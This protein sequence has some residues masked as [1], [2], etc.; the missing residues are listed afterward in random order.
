MIGIRIH[1]CALVAAFLAV[2]GTGAAQIGSSDEIS[3]S[4]VGAV[5]FGMTVEQAAAAGVPLTAAA[6]ATG[7][8]CF[9]AHPAGRPG[10]SFVVRDGTI[11]RADMVKP[12]NLKTVDGFKRGDP[13][14]TVLSYYVASS[15]GAS[16]F[17]F[18]ETS[19]VT[20]IASP[21]FSRGDGVRRLVYEITSA[22]GVIAI[23]AGLVPRDLRRC[24]TA[25]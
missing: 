16:D 17:P 2:T 1:A 18:S 22:N 9:S 4:G 6:H 10:L 3:V 20:L 5:R 25:A 11:V 23:H 21:E 13:E 8:R 14:T 12:A 19:D 7:A 15:G 24:A